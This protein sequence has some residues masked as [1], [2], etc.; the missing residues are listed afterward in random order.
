M[1][2]TTLKI[3]IRDFPENE[4]NRLMSAAKAMEEKMEEQLE[5]KLKERGEQ[6]PKQHITTA[7]D[8]ASQHIGR[9]CPQCGNQLMDDAVFCRKCGAKVSE[10]EN[11][12][13]CVKE[14]L[15]TLGLAAYA[16]KF[17]DEGYD[18]WDQIMEMTPEKLDEL[19]TFLGL[20]RG[21]AE[22]LKQHV[23]NKRLLASQEAAIPHATSAASD[24]A[25]AFTRMDANGDGQV[26]QE[27]L[28]AFLASGGSL[29]PGTS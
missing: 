2:N 25:A 18:A 15:R 24:A 6:S 28:T 3:A 27:E 17:I 11:A 26:S 9:I 4:H 8:V 13:N 23:A 1:P 5:E 20:K 29:G 12:E 22:R 21:H 7:Q 19:T 16:D 10:A 14:N